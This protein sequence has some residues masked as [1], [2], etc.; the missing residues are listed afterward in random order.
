MSKLQEEPSSLKRSLT[1]PLLVFYGVGTMLGLGIYIFIGKVIGTAGMLAP[2]A[3]VI[4]SIVA[5]F[6]GLS[7]GE[8]AGRV[9]KSA[10][11]MN[12][13]HRAFNLKWLSAI[14]GWLIVLSVIVSTATALNG[15][16]GYVHVFV[17]LPRWLIVT[18]V[19]LILT[20]VAAWGI[21]E[22]ARLILIVSILDVAALIFIMF[23]TGDVLAQLPTRIGEMVPSFQLSDWSLLFSAAFLA[24]YMFIGFEDMVNLSEEV[25]RPGKNMARGIW[26]AL[27]IVAVIYLIISTIA[28]LAPVSLAN[29]E[30][31]IAELLRSEAPG[32]EKIVSVVPLIT[33]INGV[34]VQV[35]VG[36]RLMYGMAE[37]KMAPKIFHRVNPI[38]RTPIFAT[39]FIGVFIIVLALNFSLLS[40][41]KASVFI[42]IIVFI[43]CNLSLI[44]LKR[45]NPDPEGVHT[46]PMIVPV[47]GFVFSLAILCLQIFY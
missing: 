2:M 13:I 24:F 18:S 45:R 3:F 20:A 19:I 35:I 27:A 42:L 1:L 40:L 39:F 5:V 34:L 29:S 15:Y 14:M 41:G 47:L 22:S 26:I 17:D 30:A 23:L 10:G 8:L 33:L 28:V 37:K 6:S 32:F 25:K 43:L 31:P 12:F 44:V 7:F 11:E 21:T 36:A 4:A 16:V 38:T 46:F 9:P